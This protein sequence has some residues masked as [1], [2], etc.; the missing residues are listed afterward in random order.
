MHLVL[1][2]S[3]Q[4][5][6]ARRCAGR[7][8][9]V[10]FFS[11]SFAAGSLLFALGTRKQQPAGN[12]KTCRKVTEATSCLRAVARV[13]VCVVRVVIYRTGALDKTRLDSQRVTRLCGQERIWVG[14]G[15]S[16]G[17]REGRRSLGGNGKVRCWKAAEYRPYPGLKVVDGLPL[18]YCLLRRRRR[19]AWLMARAPRVALRV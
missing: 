19:R 2:A 9:A 18:S 3:L 12:D 11:G 1:L 15:G 17:G 13:C 8:L 7:V 10:S 16:D 14:K 5:S 4:Q 6:Q